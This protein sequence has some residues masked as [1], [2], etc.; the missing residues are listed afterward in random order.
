MRRARGR[1]LR[2]VRMLKMKGRFI[3]LVGFLLSAWACSGPHYFDLQ[4]EIPENHID[5]RHDRILLV[6][7]VEINQTY[8]DYR[9]V[10]RESPFQVK[11]HNSAFW[12]KSP[13]EL[14]EDAVVLFWKKRAVFKKVSAYGST[15]KPDWTMRIYIDAIEKVQSQKKWYAR[16]AMEME[17][18]NNENNEILLVH[19]F[20][21]KSALEK[22]RVGQIPQRISR[23][24]HEELLQIEAKLMKS[25]G[26]ATDGPGAGL[27]A[28]GT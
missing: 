28:T 23:I 6:E 12:S 3:L 19:S 20:D 9:I 21:R 18:T 2:E 26:T 24:L 17:I 11:Y 4:T 14:I 1:I 25:G 7:D 10:Y 13:D 16:L 22:N 27:A 15:D 5:F 8:R